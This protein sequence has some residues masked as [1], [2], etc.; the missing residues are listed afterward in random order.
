MKKFLVVDDEK[1][2]RE[3]I[4]E[5]IELSFS[6]EVDIAEEGNQA[7][8]LCKENDYQLILTD[9]NMPNGMDGASLVK[10]LKKDGFK[11]NICVMS[12]YSENDHLSIKNDV[13]LFLKKPLKTSEMFSKLRNLINE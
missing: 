3:L 8:E 12:G 4:Q 5:L 11:N 6:I 9:I 13:D 7:L 1:L 2:I 10:N